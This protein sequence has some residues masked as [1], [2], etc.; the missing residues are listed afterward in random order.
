MERREKNR[1]TCKKTENFGQHSPHSLL[2]YAL[3]NWLFCP[4]VHSRVVLIPLL[5]QIGTEES[6]QATTK[7]KS[8]ELGKDR[9]IP[10]ITAYQLKQQL[11]ED[12]CGNKLT[13]RC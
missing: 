7:K 11:P 5:I 6:G 13:E 2:K 4:E 10:R 9:K 3:W 1:L 8:Q 12:H